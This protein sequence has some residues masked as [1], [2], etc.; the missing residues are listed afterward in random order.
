METKS[1]SKKIKLN[2]GCGRKY[3]KGWLNVDLNPLYNAD[4]RFNVANFP[5]P[6]QDSTVQE[7]LCSHILEHFTTSQFMNFLNEA[8]RISKRNGIIV[9]KVPFYNNAVH[10]ANWDHKL[11]F[12]FNT[13]K[14]ICENKEKTLIFTDFN[15]TTH[16]IDLT[17]NF[18]LLSVKSKPSKIGKFIPN[19][20]R[21]REY[22]SYVLGQITEEITYVLRVI[23]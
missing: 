22:L 5:Y 14:K 17:Y 21:F 6:L 18:K 10:L 16:K 7:I 15:G 19:I 4:K 11:G 9:I 3:K 12:E 13:F 2:L 1:K 20:F 8:Y 23:K